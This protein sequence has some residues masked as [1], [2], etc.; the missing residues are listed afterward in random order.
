MTTTIQYVSI[1][2]RDGELHTFM[3]TSVEAVEKIAWPA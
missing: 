3:V 1:N 2:D